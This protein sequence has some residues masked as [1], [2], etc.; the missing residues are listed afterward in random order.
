M[1]LG[2]VR[3]IFLIILSMNYFFTEVNPYS[4][5]SGLEN[6]SFPGSTPVYHF[7]INAGLNTRQ[8]FTGLSE[9]HSNYLSCLFN[10]RIGQSWVNKPQ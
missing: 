8:L 2:Q 10:F 9:N 4:R 7:A 1:S 6:V 5:I 3:R